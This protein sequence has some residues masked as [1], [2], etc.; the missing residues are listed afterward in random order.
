V[1]KNDS[2]IILILSETTA[3]ESHHP[4]LLDLLWANSSWQKIKTLYEE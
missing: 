2:V 4:S 1:N 3:I